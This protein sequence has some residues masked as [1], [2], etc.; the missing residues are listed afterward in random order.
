LEW[1]GESKTGQY[2]WHERYAIESAN[3]EFNKS[4]RVFFMGGKDGE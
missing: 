1:E 4:K 3:E 2:Y